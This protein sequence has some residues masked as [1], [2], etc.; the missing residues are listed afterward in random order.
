[1]KPKLVIILGPTGAGKS[2]V[3]VD[4]ALRLG[5]EVVNADS[6]LVYRYMDIGT[7][8]PATEA[9]EKVRHHLID[10][11]DPDGGF[12]AALYRESA[13]K[14]IQEITAR[15]KKAIVCGGTGLYLRALVQG[16]F[17]GP[18]KSPEVRKRLETQAQENGLSVLYER[19]RE[20]DPDAT[21]WIHPNDR[22]RIIRALEVFELTGKGISSWQKE[23][24]FAESAFEVIKIG[25][26][27]ERQELYDLINQRCDEMIAG[28]LVDEV[29]GLVEKGYSLD[30]PAL[31]SVGYRQIGLYLRGE[32]SL[33]EAVILIKRDTRHL[34][35][36]Q[37]T[38][39]RADKQIRWFYPEKD[40]E[41]IHKAVKEFFM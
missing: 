24:G 33:D 5:G 4:I 23:H 6:Q 31:Q 25:L 26:N 10:L 14:A 37:L 7:A 21:R 29:K 22:Y 36:R 17:A 1:M 9:R 15:G 30:L 38:W 13:L 27:R 20:V 40:R 18:G 3:A 28:G 8:K 41:K 11:V 32:L 35:K 19:L 34:A 39:F 12:N 16:L 2:E